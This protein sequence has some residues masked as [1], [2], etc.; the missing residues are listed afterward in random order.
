[1]G[2]VVICPL[3]ALSNFYNFL[4][5]CHRQ[6]GQCGRTVHII[7]SR[8]LFTLIVHQYG[9]SVTALVTRI[10]TANSLFV[11]PRI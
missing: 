4:K 1:M 11:F 7:N 3:L 2:N 10:M 9:A 5:E 6:K 8:R